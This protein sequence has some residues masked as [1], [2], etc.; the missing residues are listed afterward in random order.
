MLPVVAVET[1]LGG[2]R[3]V[4]ATRKKIRIFESGSGDLVHTLAAGLEPGGRLLSAQDGGLI[5]V[6][7]PGRVAIWAVQAGQQLFELGDEE[8]RKIEQL[9]EQAVS[10]TAA[11]WGTAK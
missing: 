1:A 7:N 5:A 2:R 3:V 6:V 10:E 8:K 4:T 9:V 11:E